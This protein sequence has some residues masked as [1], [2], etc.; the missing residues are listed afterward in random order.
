MPRS[1]HARATL[2]PPLPAIRLLGAIRV[3]RVVRLLNSIIGAI[4]QAH[5]A[6]KELLL[7]EKQNVEEAQE[8]H[9]RLEAALQREVDAKARV[10]DM[11]RSYK[12]EVDTLREALHIAARTVAE[13]QGYVGPDAG[14]TDELRQSER[15][16]LRGVLRDAAASVPPQERAR[17]RGKGGQGGARRVVVGEDGSYEEV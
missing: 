10:E 7:E 5:D 2:V 15:A 17:L 16:E 3:W 1:C 13:A 12:E 11:L 6:T 9:K 4:E 8:E 14:A